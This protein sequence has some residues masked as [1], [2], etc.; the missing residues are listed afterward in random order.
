VDEAGLQFDLHFDHIGVV[1]PDIDAGRRFLEAAL[2]ISQ[3]T[4]VFED[5]GLGVAVQFG[6]ALDG[7]VYELISPLG[8]TSPVTAALKA[9]KNI[10][11]HMAYLTA[12]IASAGERLRAQGCYPAG[13]PRPALAYGGRRVQFF[14]SPL[15]FLIEIIESPGHA[16]TFV[17]GPAR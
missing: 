10:L 9:G 13:E 8:D 11:N 17:E 7:P 15:R 1:V 6:R 4:A 3:W 5:P 14:V 12:N 2:G 16:H